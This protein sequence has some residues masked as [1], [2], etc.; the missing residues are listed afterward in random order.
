MSPIKSTVLTLACLGVVTG[1]LSF[2]VSL[3]MWFS[4][5]DDA[6]GMCCLAVGIEVVCIPLVGVLGGFK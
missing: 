1:V 4:G 2:F 3:L 6:G 5:I